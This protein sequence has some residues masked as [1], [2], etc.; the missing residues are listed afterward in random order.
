MRFF[1]VENGRTGLGF[2]TSRMQER[3]KVV[4][5]RSDPPS[6]DQGFFMAGPL[7]PERGLRAQDCG[8]IN[9][10]RCPFVVRFRGPC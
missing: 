3:D 5:P 1:L 9:H 8:H 6:F 7:E 4:R 2:L 10:T